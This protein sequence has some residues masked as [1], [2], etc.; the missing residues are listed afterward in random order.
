MFS[1]FHQE[2]SPPKN[3]S[4]PY[5][6]S[7]PG[8]VAC[9]LGP[10]RQPPCNREESQCALTIAGARGSRGVPS[11]GLSTSMCNRPRGRYEARAKEQKGA[12]LPT[13]RVGP[14]VSDYKAKEKDGIEPLVF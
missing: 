8:V 5:D 2:S 11:I 4:A 12:R 9:T 10:S 6:R 3:C 7:W 1:V 14:R 13:A